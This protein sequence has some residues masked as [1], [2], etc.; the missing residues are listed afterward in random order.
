MHE[1]NVE[2]VNGCYRITGTRVSLNSIVYAYLNGESAE[3]IA[4]SFPVLTLEQ[5]RGAIDFYLTHQEEIDSYLESMRAEY[6]ARRQAAR[7]ADPAFYQKMADGRRRM[8]TPR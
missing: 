6:E 4:D 2:Q 1:G 3:S 7:D 5:V 8:L